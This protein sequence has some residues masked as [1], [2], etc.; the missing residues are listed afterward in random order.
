VPLRSDLPANHPHNPAHLAAKG[1]DTPKAEEGSEAQKTAVEKE[2]AALFTKHFPIDKIEEEIPK[3]DSGA[4][5]LDKIVSKLMK[6]T[7]APPNLKD[8]ITEH[9]KGHIDQLKKDGKVEAF[10]PSDPHGALYRPEE[11]A[12]PEKPAKGE[13]RTEEGPQPNIDKDK[14]RKIPSL[15]GATYHDSLEVDDYPYGKKRTKAKFSVETMKNGKQRG[16]KQTL[17]PKTGQWNKPK[18]T[19]SG[20]KVKIVQSG[21]KTYIATDTGSGAIYLQNSA[22]KSEGYVYGESGSHFEEGAGHRFVPDAKASDPGHH[23]LHVGIHGKSEAQKY[24][25]L[26]IR[27][28][29]ETKSAVPE[30]KKA[31]EVT[32][33]ET[34]EEKPSQAG[35]PLAKSDPDKLKAIQEHLLSKHM[36]TNENEIKAQTETLKKPCED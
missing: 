33:K 10:N 35:K 19:T 16:V 29:G 6:K 13:T 24:A 11:G 36:S 5:S 32:A 3:S 2:K 18:K 21:G 34:T 28:K 26:G 27:K 23:E 30:D 15:D 20:D 4:L 12:K 14:K 1:G 17:N 8:D 7:D 9:I 22:F 25:D 31:P